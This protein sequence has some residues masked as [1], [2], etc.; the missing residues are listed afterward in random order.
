MGDENFRP[1]GIV[2]APDGSVFISDWV[3]KSYSVHG[4]GRVWRIRSRV[5][6]PAT[7]HRPANGRA[8]DAARACIIGKSLHHGVTLRK[9]AARALACGSAAERKI[10]HDRLQTVEDASP[11]R[12]GGS[13][14]CRRLAIY[15][16]TKCGD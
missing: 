6:L 7:T 11:A 15:Q 5:Q 10:L 16:P 1:V 9:A 3:D 8:E 12:D 14:P 2:V 13:W 4:Q